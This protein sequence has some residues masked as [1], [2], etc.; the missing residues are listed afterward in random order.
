MALR[1]H[2]FGQSREMEQGYM[3]KG[4]KWFISNQTSYLGVVMT[5]TQC[6]SYECVAVV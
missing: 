5:E 4:I 2:P 1:W 6:S 3:R